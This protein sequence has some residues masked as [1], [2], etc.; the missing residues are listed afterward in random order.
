MACSDA[1]ARTGSDRNSVYG[2]LR[3]ASTMGS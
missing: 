3:P 1:A 2:S